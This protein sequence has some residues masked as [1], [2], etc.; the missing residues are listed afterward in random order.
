MRSEPLGREKKPDSITVDQTPS[1]KQVEEH[2]GYSPQ[3][4]RSDDEKILVVV[5][6]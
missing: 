1:W 3:T 2:S 5:Q 4:F 6:I